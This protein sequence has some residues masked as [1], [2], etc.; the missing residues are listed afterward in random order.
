MLI[1]PIG[2][3]K[4]YIACAIGIAACHSEHAVHCTRMDDLAL[5]PVIARGDRFAHQNLLNKLSTVDLLTFGIDETAVND[6]FTVR[7]NKDQRL[8]TMI[9]SQSGPRYWIESLA[10]EVA[11]DS[12]VNRLTI[13]ART[14]NLG[15]IDMRRLHTQEARDPK[16]HWE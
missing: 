2:A 11:A 6:L 9:A 3:G 13:R 4:T 1:S 16:D 10:E 15:V 14:I 7:V 12:I 8:P 5:E